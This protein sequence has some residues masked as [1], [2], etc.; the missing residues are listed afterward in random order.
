M[1]RQ[2][3]HER[4]SEDFEKALRGMALVLCKLNGPSMRVD[5]PFLR[6]VG[7]EAYMVSERYSMGR[8]SGSA[9]MSSST[10]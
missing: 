4:R 2:A 8:R 5:G 9:Q 1:V 10:S 7:P 6:L 3:H